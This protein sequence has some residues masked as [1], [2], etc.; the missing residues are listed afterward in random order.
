MKKTLTVLV[1]VVIGIFFHG[2]HTLAKP[3]PTSNEPNQAAYLGPIPPDKLKQ[4]L[5]F[6]FKTIEEVHPNMYA[7]TSK[8][9]F[10]PLSH[11]LYQKINRPMS[12]V[13]FYKAVAPVVASLKS[14]HTIMLPFVDEYQQHAKS[15]GKVFPLELRWD[16]TS[17]IL[18][19]NYTPVL[20]PAGARITKINGRAA[21]ELF[22]NFSRWFAAENIGTNPWLIEHPVFLRALLLLEY[23]PVE[24]WHLKIETTNGR[25][26]SYTVP[27]FT[28]S[29]FKTD[30]AVATVERKEYYRIIPEYNAAIIKF[31]K[32][33]GPEKLKVFF[34]ETFQDIHEKRIANLIIDI[35]ENTG[36]SDECVHMI[37]EYLATTPYRKYERVS[38]KIS[39]QTHDR[40]ACLRR[41]FADKF[42]NKENGDI[43]TFE[44]P[45]QSPADNPFKFS[46]RTFVLIS[47]RSFSASTVFASVVKCAQIATLIGEE[48]GDPTTLY[49]DSIKFKLPNSGLGAWVASKLLVCACGK[50]DGRG[51]IP[52]YEVKQTIQDTAKGVDTVVQFTLNLIKDPNSG[53]QQK[54]ANPR[55][56]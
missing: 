47:P 2:S 46:G 18:V 28:L 51:V 15:G 22:T 1:S 54:G 5:D 29:E 36:G 31:F 34:N 50:P 17:A 13:E 27:S 8:E 39:S 37:M 30:E 52:D 41:E 42:A 26:E 25:I 24:S 9:Q 4:D 40:I 32:W 55:G 56:E 14:F 48:T 44:L 43:V 21:T 38:I 23:G 10:T 16:E 20:L 35:R 7:Y 49:A 45:T 11:E 33:S 12:R 3:Q 19:K 6:L 53:I